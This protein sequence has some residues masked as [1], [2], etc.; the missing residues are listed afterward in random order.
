MEWEPLH[1]DH[2]QMDHPFNSHNVPLLFHVTPYSWS[3]NQRKWSFN[4]HCCRAGCGISSQQVILSLAL[5]D[6]YIIRVLKNTDKYFKIKLYFTLLS[7]QF[8]H[9][10]D[11]Q[12]FLF[13]HSGGKKEREEKAHLSSCKNHTHITQS[14]LNFNIHKAKN[15]DTCH[16]YEFKL[17]RKIDNF[18]LYLL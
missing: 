6:P 8:R 9:I 4:K 12:S 11:N 14:V 3:R 17:Q 16:F 13:F 2:V 18:P 5:T 10:L 15:P 1:Y 7:N